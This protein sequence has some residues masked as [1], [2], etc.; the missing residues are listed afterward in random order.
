MGKIE[1]KNPDELGAHHCTRENVSYTIAFLRRIEA[2]EEDSS[3]Q[4]WRTTCGV[5]A[6]QMEWLLSNFDN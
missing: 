2:G 3:I 5:L 1:D 4:D 6:L